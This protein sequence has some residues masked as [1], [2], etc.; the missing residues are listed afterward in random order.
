MEELPLPP[1]HTPALPW[2]SAQSEGGL[3]A[4][5]SSPGAWPAGGGGGLAGH[6]ERA[7]PGQKE[8]SQ[9]W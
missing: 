2:T 1:A 8:A 3:Q 9:G 5:P 4:L 7:S 6:V